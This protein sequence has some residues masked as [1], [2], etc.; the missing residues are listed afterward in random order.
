MLKVVCVVGTWKCSIQIEVVV[1]CEI[2]D[3]SG[4]VDLK[5]SVVK[6]ERMEI[7][8]R[9]GRKEGEIWSGGFLSF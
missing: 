3:D 8:R 1:R 4:C 2:S 5:S 9:E 6:V 7:W